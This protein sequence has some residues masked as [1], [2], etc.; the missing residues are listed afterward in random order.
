MRCVEAALAIGL[1]TPLLLPEAV[2]GPLPDPESIPHV[3]RRGR[4]AFIDY[5]HADDHRAFAI[6]PGGAWGWVADQASPEA[7]RSGALKACQSA[8]QQ[9]CQLYAIDDRLVFDPKR[10]SE[11]W[12]VMRRGWSNEP[13]AEGVN[14]GEQF[15]DLTFRDAS[16][17]MQ[18]ISDFRGRLL[19]VHF[20][21]SWCPP[22][23]RELPVLHRFYR[24]LPDRLA[25]RIA[26]VLLQVREPAA[27]A[28][29]WLR[30]NRL[31]EL[32]LFDSGNDG[33]G[34]ARFFR[35]EGEPLPDRKV[36]ARFPTSYFLD[37]QGR[38][39]LRR[40]GPIERWRDYLPLI[41]SLLESAPDNTR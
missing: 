24:G 37:P 41:A 18:R 15:Y 1:L 29:Q 12:R 27:S 30:E 14:A 40:I 36:A 11:S 20:W 4:A 10:W 39:L 21:G 6:A 16:G 25:E 23:M 13:L 26:L 28:R 17:E 33:K 7:A 3:D 9:R 19:I 8:T 34:P 31:D 5:R 35:A 38:V 22:C 32:P 2:A